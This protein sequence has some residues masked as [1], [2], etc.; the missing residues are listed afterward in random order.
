[1]TD[2]L[3][4]LSICL[5]NLLCG[6]FFFISYYGILLIEKNKNKFVVYILD[7]LSILLLGFIYLIVVDANKITFH[8]YDLIFIATGYILGIVLFSKQLQISYTT[9]F[10]ILKYLYNKF[11]ILITWC[12]DIIPFK[13][14]TKKIKIILFK[15]KLKRTIRKVNKKI[16]EKSLD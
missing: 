2:P 12:F 11:K 9:L 7:F 8:L 13:I 14:L 3:L 4:D 10:I 16:K 6:I 1:M 5:I 15:L